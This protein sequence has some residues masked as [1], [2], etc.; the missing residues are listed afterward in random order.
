MSQEREWWKGTGDEQRRDLS[1]AISEDSRGEYDE[2][3]LF[4][5]MSLGVAAY[6]LMRG[7]ATLQQGNLVLA[8]MIADCEIKVQECTSQLLQLTDPSTPEARQLHFIAR[9]H[10]G[11]IGKLNEYVSAGAVAAETINGA[12][13]QS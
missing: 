11:I 9:V 12:D 3:I 4:A 10:A 13:P 8:T 2:S 1:E 5:K 7:L 6:R